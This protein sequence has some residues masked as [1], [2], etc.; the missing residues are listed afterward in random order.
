MTK[1]KWIALSKKIDG[2]SDWTGRLFCWLV[3]PLTVL[4]VYEVFTRRFLN[5]PT[6]WTFELSNFLYG[7]HF[8]LV[9]AY[10][11]LHNAHVR[12]DLFVIKGSKRTQEILDLVGY[13]L[14]FFPFMIV[15]IYH[16]TAWAFDSWAGWEVSNSLWGPP[17]YYFKTVIP[18][19]AVLLFLQGVSEV[20]KKVIF[21]KTGE[22]I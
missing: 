22:A 18:V 2:V 15:I 20:I 8:M 5:A 11:L 12:I 7:T 10:G 16:G 17:L 21:L 6:I 4:I 1:E 14:L 3:I 9:A 13:A 19:M